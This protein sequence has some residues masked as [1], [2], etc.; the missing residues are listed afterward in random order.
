ML[1]GELR[2]DIYAVLRSGDSWT[3]SLYDEG[4]AVTPDEFVKGYR[5]YFKLGESCITRFAEPS[6]SGC[7]LFMTN[8][9]GSSEL[10]PAAVFVP[11]GVSEGA[12]RRELADRFRAE[13]SNFDKAIRAAGEGD[14]PESDAAA[15]S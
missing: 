1:T 12:A 8:S 13:V 7:R 5:A 15:L 6:E 3:M 2:G 14:V 9:G 11:N 10:R 4:Q